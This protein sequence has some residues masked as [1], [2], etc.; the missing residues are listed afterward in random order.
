MPRAP[1]VGPGSPLSGRYAPRWPD[2]LLGFDSPDRSESATWAPTAGPADATGVGLGP[3]GPGLTGPAV[4]LQ[5]RG[6][7]RDRTFREGSDTT[8]GDTGSRPLAHDP[9]LAPADR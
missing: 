5:E 2:T 1:K 7:R 4:N 3:P 6:Q 8:G 9:V